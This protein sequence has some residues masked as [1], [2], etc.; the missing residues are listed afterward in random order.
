MLVGPPRITE[1]LLGSNSILSDIG[2]GGKVLPHCYTLTELIDVFQR[3][4]TQ[5][6]GEPI[7]KEIWT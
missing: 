2:A 1:A 6:V 7:T 4:F 5:F 3:Y